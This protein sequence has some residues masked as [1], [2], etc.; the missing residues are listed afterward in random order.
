LIYLGTMG[1]SYPFWVGKLYPCYSKQQD[2]L[3]YYSREFNSVEIDYTFYRIPSKTSVLEWGSSVPND[4][5]FSVKMHRDITHAK[6]LLFDDPKL[7]VFLER[8]KFF[9]NKLGP[10]LLQFPPWLKSDKI[11]E[12]ERLLTQFPNNI[13]LALEFRNGSWLNDSVYSILQNYPVSLVGINKKNYSLG[14]LSK[15]FY[16]RFEGDRKLVNGE[17]GEIEINKRQEIVEL[18]SILLSLINCGKNVYGYFSK[19][20]SGYPPSDVYEMKNQLKNIEFYL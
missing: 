17:K 4:F 18:S 6:N 5:Q 12:L 11:H 10:I 13:Q 14:K 19:Y 7:V 8:I 16:F 15:F 9:E 20:F 1:W 3:K 2:Y